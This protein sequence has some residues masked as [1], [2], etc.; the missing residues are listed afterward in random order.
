MDQER[1]DSFQ[2]HKNEQHKNDSVER[3]SD[4]VRESGK[5]C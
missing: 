5:N 4:D 1:V 3:K 2:L